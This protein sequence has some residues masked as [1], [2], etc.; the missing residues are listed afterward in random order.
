MAGSI[1]TM[2]RGEAPGMGSRASPSRM[3]AGG[4]MQRAP[5]RVRVAQLRPFIGMAGLAGTLAFGLV[6]ALRA[7]AAPSHVVPSSRAGVPG[8]LSG[9]LPGSGPTLQWH[10]FSLLLIGL[11]ACYLVVLACADTLSPRLVLAVCFVAVAVFTL[12]PPLLSGDIFGY[13]DWAR[14]AMLK[15]LDPYTHGSLSAP[16]DPVFKYMMW[17]GDT[18]TPPRPR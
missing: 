6:I 16:H 3:D 4:L 2:R 11:S 1:P 9:P 10:E 17:R 13:I 8:W 14:M 18:P 7:S 12:A 15:G 5:A